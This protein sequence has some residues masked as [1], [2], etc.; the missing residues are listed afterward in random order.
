MDKLIAITGTNGKTTT[1]YM[2]KSILESSGGKVGLIGTEGAFVRGQY[3]EVNL[4]TPDPM[5]LHKLF[6]IM[7]DNGCEYC[8]MEASAHSLFHDKLYGIKFDVAIFSNFTQDN[9]DFFKNMENYS[10]A[11]LKLFEEKVCKMAVINFDD[12]FGRKLQDLNLPTRSR[13]KR[14]K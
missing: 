3:F 5:E 9:L 6:K 2:M 11:K 8:V 4:T 12:E 7:K 13:V 10:Q 14:G 1:T